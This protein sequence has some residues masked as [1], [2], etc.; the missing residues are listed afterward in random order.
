MQSEHPYLLPPRDIRWLSIRRW[1]RDWIGNLG[2]PAW[3]P[4]GV[5][6]LG[7]ALSLWG[8]CQC[9]W[10][11]ASEKSLCWR[12]D[13]GTTSI[14]GGGLAFGGVSWGRLLGGNHFELGLK[15]TTIVDLLF[16][17]C[18]AA[19]R[20]AGKGAGCWTRW[21]DRRGG[22]RRAH[23][24]RRHGGLRWR[25]AQ[26]PGAGGGL[27][28]CVT[29]EKWVRSVGRGARE[30]RAPGVGV[31]EES[32]TG[33]TGLELWESRLAWCGRGWARWPRGRRPP[34]LGPGAE[35]GTIS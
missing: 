26:G 19:C 7:D 15:V 2:V 5:R 32:L 3:G 13:L 12:A 22:W 14:S 30:R 35:V 4:K 21:G 31:G 24:G 33:D 1:V 11:M 9:T 23:G 20:A 17:G 27:G 8:S 34:G 25:A 18:Q 16:S 10:E 6:R 28:E 29:L